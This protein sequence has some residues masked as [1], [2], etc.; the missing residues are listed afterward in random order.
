MA[1]EPFLKWAGGKRWLVSRFAHLFPATFDRYIEPFLGSGAVFF[2]LRPTRALLSDTNA[3]LIN[4]YRAVRLHA[5]E[6]AGRLAK[7]HAAHGKA[8]YYAMR[9][10]QPKSRLDR[11]V[12]FL[13]LN[14][15]CFNGLYRVN[16]NGHFNVPLGSKIDVAFPDG[17]LESAARAL[18]G[19]LLRT[20]D[21]ED[22]VDGTGPGD[23]LFVDPPYTVMHNSNNFVKY[24]AHLFS[25]D[26]QKRLAAAVRRAAARGSAIVLSNADHASVRQLYRGFGTHLRL[27]RPTRLAADSRCRTETTELLVTALPKGTRG[28]AKGRK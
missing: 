13:Y 22:I 28:P 5:T 23:L 17:A 9:S 25:W 27:D 14:R 18:A 4:T 19:A 26:D 6:I 12:R 16:R 3:E 8:Q 2:H 24:N 21:F 11:A 15:T 20:A 1:I 7:L 10:S